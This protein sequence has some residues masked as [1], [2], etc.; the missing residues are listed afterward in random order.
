ML[1]VTLKRLLL[2]TGERAARD[3]VSLLMVMRDSRLR[4]C[5]GQPSDC[6]FKVIV[7]VRGGF[8]K[9]GCLNKEIGVY[10]GLIAAMMK[11]T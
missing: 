1:A 7:H 8:N 6:N 10:K 11:A 2:V 3:G 4:V 9:R 5:S